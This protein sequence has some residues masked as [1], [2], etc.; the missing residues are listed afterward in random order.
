[1]ALIAT[2]LAAAA[3]LPLPAQLRLGCVALACATIVVL[4]L[5]RLRAHGARRTDART[6]GLYAR[7]DRI[8]SER[9]NRRRRS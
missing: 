5:V 9:E 3:L 1:V 7:I 6:D 2:L 8:R 4:L